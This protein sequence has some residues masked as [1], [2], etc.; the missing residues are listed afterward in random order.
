[1]TTTAMPPEVETYLARVRAALGDLPVDERDD[2][3]ADVEASVVEA[4]AEG[5]SVTARLGQPEDFAAELRAAAG[6]QQVEP[7]A[8]RPGLRESVRSALARPRV[9]ALREALTSLAP[10]WWVARAYVAVAALALW[11][12]VPWSST[13]F[14]VPLLENGIF[15]VLAL[16]L[17]S[18]ASV[19][20][21]LRAPTR[22]P[23]PRRVAAAA[24]VLLAL[25][26]LPVLGHLLNQH[27]AAAPLVDGAPV[28]TGLAYEGVPIDNI[29]PYARDGRLLQDVLLYDG[30]GRPLEVRP[31]AYDPD[32]RLLV[33]PDG[34][35]IF[36]SFPVR[37][38]EPGTTRVE[39]P[40]AAP[41]IRIPEIE[42]P[43]LDERD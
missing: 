29:Y 14:P 39:R 8:P 33:R 37:Y 4:A 6:L 17:A 25:A 36:N 7:A 35:P 31:G 23:R 19:W 22:T 9:L 13:R 28:V 34:T 2:L 21:G 40:D 27:P 20:L 11:W 26:A 38:F 12:D 15:G 10:V 3:L 24:N 18:A 32:R 30:A 42:T 41:P 5:G 1:M 16:V 43:P